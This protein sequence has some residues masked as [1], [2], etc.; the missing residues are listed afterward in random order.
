VNLP[1]LLAKRV[2]EYEQMPEVRAVGLLELATAQCVSEAVEDAIRHYWPYSAY[3]VLRAMAWTMKHSSAA[4][5]AWQ[6]EID[7]LLHVLNV[8]RAVPPSPARHLIDEAKVTT[9]ELGQQE[10]EVAQSW[11]REVEIWPRED[12]ELVQRWLSTV[13]TWEFVDRCC[14]FEAHAALTFWSALLLKGR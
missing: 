14:A 10:R 7:V 4:A 6:N 5:D 1:E 11:K 12:W 9:N 13:R 8:E 3:I 2:S